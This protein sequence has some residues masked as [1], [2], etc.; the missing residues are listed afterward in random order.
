MGGEI[1]KFSEKGEIFL[2]EK[3]LKIFCEFLFWYVF[4]KKKIL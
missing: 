3:K 1:G 2:V 4:K